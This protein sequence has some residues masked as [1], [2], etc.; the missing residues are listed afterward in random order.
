[1]DSSTLRKVG[2]AYHNKMSL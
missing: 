1:M 2:L